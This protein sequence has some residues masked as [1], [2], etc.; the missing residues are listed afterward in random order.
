VAQRE[1]KV[2]IGMHPRL[3]AALNVHS[4]YSFVGGVSSPASLTSQAARLGY[5]HLALTDTNGIYGAVDLINASKEKV[6]P[7]IGSSLHLSHGGNVYPLVLLA[8]SKTGYQKL[9][10]LITLAKGNDQQAITL[11]MLEAHNTDLHCLTG[12]RKGIVTKLL[13]SKQVGEAKKVLQTLKKSFRDRLWMQLYYDHYRYDRRRVNALHSLAHS[14]S[15]AC[16]AAPEI[17]YATGDK[18]RLYDTL[19][20]ARLGVALNDSLR[21]RPLNAKQCIPEATPY[22]PAESIYNANALAQELVFDLLPDRLTPPPA[23]TRDGVSADVVLE[24]LCRRKLLELYRGSSFTKAADRLERELYVIRSLGF[25]DFFLVVREVLE[26]CQARGI[27]ASGRG[28]AAGSVICFLLGITRVDPIEHDLLFERFLHLSKDQMPDIDID[29]SSSRRPELFQWLVERFPHS[30]MA[31]N[32][33]TYFLPSAIKDVGRALGLPFEMTDKLSD[34]LGRD[35]RGLRPHKARQAEKIFTEVLGNAPVKERLLCLLED[36]EPGFV[37]GMSPHSGGWVL[38]KYDLTQYTPL[39]T[40][41]GGFRCGQFD[42]DHVEQLGL[43]KLDLLGLRMLGAHERTREEKFR[44]DGETINITNPPDD[45]AVWLDI[46]HGDTIGIFQIESPGQ[47]RIS[48]QLKPTTKQQLHIQVA[49]FRPGPIQS[50]TVNPYIRRA[51]GLEPVTYPHPGLERILKPTL[52]V[53]L[54]QEQIMSIAHDWAGMSWEEADKFK[55]HV[56]TFEDEYEIRDERRRFIEGA[57]RTSGASEKEAARVFYLC[58]L[59]RGYGF[60]QSHS[61]AFG[62]HAYVSAYLRHKYPAEYFAALMSEQPGMYSL[63]TL[64][65]ELI[66][67]GI[68]YGRIDINKSHFYYRVEKT[69]SG[70]I[71]RPPLCAPKKVSKETAQHIILQR[72]EGGSFLSLNDFMNRCD[73]DKLSLEALARAG[74]F[75]RFTTRREALYQ[76]SVLANVKRPREMMLYDAGEIPPFPKLSTMD[77]I[78][79]DFFV[80]GASH[81][82]VHPTDFYR[83]SLLDHGAT[84]MAQL[85]GAQGFVR[86]GGIVVAKQ[87]PPTA[88]NFA[89]F[90]LEDGPEKIQLVIPPN[91]WEENYQTLR[92]ATL[93]LSEGRLERNSMAWTLKAERVWSLHA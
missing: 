39:E 27:V 3:T 68:G 11:S 75:D 40:S 90:L 49:I 66:R 14:L 83:Q 15:I 67:H 30:C 73:V 82:A 8:S 37:R 17:R 60:A 44:V 18:F 13:E 61:V 46:G 43:M 52:G 88:N 7:I 81:H 93:L 76:L 56:T 47:I 85:R 58:S 33:L 63:N 35:F 5:L 45:P 87:K 25:A 29:I 53:L 23:K 54:Y 36:I 70:K 6:K 34:S 89:F 41:T 77:G 10:Q 72:F 24:D 62:E 2:G 71:V 69:H 16:V 26:Y 42:K 74:A 22:F 9:N 86:T 48:T 4:Y 65:Q 91:V 20:C 55:K 28:S 59:F 79:W 21:N 84:P 51:R 32:R 12:N 38:S 1:T 78:E 50:G 19:V 80:I 92:D 31:N 57:K 64:R